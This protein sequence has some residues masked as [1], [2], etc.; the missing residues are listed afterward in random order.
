MIVSFVCIC[1][2]LSR[3]K[4]I[5]IVHASSLLIFSGEYYGKFAGVRSLRCLAIIFELT[6]VLA[7]IV[8]HREIL[9]FLYRSLIDTLFG[10]TIFFFQLSISMRPSI[11]F[12]IIH[13]SEHSK[14]LEVLV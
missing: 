14:D 13:T 4:I 9:F 8:Y 1:S 6:H 10:K 11:E 7:A 2:S 3:K 5:T 12:R